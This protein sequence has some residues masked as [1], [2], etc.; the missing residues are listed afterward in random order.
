VV[1]VVPLPVRL[2]GTEG[3]VVSP[4]DELVVVETVLLAVEWFSVL[5]K[6]TI[7]HV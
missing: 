4:L 2:A 5:S 3:A 7:V 6:A 1:E